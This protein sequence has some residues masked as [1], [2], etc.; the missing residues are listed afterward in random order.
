MAMQLT[1]P[2][3]RELPAVGLVTLWDPESGNWQVVDADRAEIR[4]QFRAART[5]FDEALATHC[6][7]LGVDLLRLDTDQPY[8]ERL[9]AFFSRRERRRL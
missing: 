1:D 9:A 5:E 6:S 7:R 2:R 4:D 8:G 3:E